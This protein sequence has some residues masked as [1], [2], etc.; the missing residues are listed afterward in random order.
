MRTKGGNYYISRMVMNKKARA[1][2]SYLHGYL[3]LKIQVA[4][5][6]CTF[7][8]VVAQNYNYI[9]PYKILKFDTTINC[10]NL[11]DVAIT[12]N[13]TLEKSLTIDEQ[14]RI[15]CENVNNTKRIHQYYPAFQGDSEIVTIY[16]QN[17]S[18]FEKIFNKYNQFG[19][20][21]KTECYA[22]DSDIAMQWKFIGSWEYI[23]D[24]CNRKSML[25]GIPGPQTNIIDEGRTIYLYDDSNRVKKIFYRCHIC[26]VPN[27]EG[28]SL[29]SV[30]TF[31]YDANGYETINVSRSSV[32]KTKIK[33]N[34]D[35]QII[36]KLTWNTSDDYVTNHYVN[37]EYIPESNVKFNFIMTKKFMYDNLSR[38]VKI[39]AYDDRN[40]LI[41]TIEL[42]YN[43]NIKVKFGEDYNTEFFR[44]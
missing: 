4:I 2:R 18:G 25:I 17:H 31:A 14:G 30:E 32:F 34:K 24:S 36:E 16:N 42:M 10:V 35:L 9:I 3:N 13:G 21:T 37:G 7:S 15:V 39:E 5:C 6:V 29:M 28:D 22:L 26:F 43:K 27:L 11:G 41:S 40:I 33:L 44:L 20:I 1:A 8:Q 23:Y 19:K 38:L 12:Y